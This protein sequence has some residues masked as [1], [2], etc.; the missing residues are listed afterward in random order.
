[1]D[2][3]QIQKKKDFLSQ[4]TDKLGSAPMVTFKG[5]PFLDEEGEKEYIMQEKLEEGQGKR[6]SKDKTRKK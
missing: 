3:E 1:M 5:Q 2:K 4:T 6:K